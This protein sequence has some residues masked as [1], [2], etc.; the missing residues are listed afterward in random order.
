MMFIKAT[1]FVLVAICIH[2]AQLIHNPLSLYVDA[3]E[4]FAIGHLQDGTKVYD[5]FT[6][7]N[8]NPLPEFICATMLG[9]H[10]S[11]VPTL[12]IKTLYNKIIINQQI[13]NSTYLLDI[14]YYD[15]VAIEDGKDASYMLDSG[16][17]FESIPFEDGSIALKCSN[18]R[19]LK[20]DAIKTR[21]SDASCP[22]LIQDM[23]DEV[24]ICDQCKFYPEV[25]SVDPVYIEIMSIDWG[26]VDGAIITN[27]S[28]VAKDQQ[29][30]YSDE[31]VE[32]QMKVMFT[33][34]TADTTIWE[35]A[36]GFEFGAESTT[37]IKI[38]FVGE[39]D[40]TISAKMSYNGKYGTSNTVTDT[41]TIEKTA[42]YPC[43]GR[44]RCF[45]NMIGRHLD[46]QQVPYTAR[47]KKT[48]GSKVE[49]WNESGVWTGLKT[50][51]TW[52]QYCTEDLDT[53]ETN[54]PEVVQIK[55]IRTL[56]TDNPEVVL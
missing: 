50:Y 46:N 37:I 9:D 24:G 20:Y 7:V 31:T 11:N 44:H 2:K 25:G 26:E 6:Y 1:F 48:V 27:P 54:C 32:L 5:A 12:D 53:H 15:Q 51:D 41:V 39:E 16:R 22:V 30:N 35:N 17:W 38:P 14:Y 28:I 47:V 23:C 33:D 18:G 29:D 36:W 10:H 21:D 43:P 34:S 49:E 3:E 8:Y 42:T 19:Y 40:I 45:Y 56:G 55:P 52:A 4:G 13:N